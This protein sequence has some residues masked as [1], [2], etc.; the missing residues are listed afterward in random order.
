MNRPKK[1]HLLIL[2]LLLAMNATGA[3]ILGDTK[4]S[5]SEERGIDVNSIATTVQ[6]CQDF[7]S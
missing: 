5:A 2:S 1:S 6:P 3:S 4:S 7:Y